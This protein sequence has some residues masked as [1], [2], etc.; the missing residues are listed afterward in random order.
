MR[1]RLTLATL[2]VCASLVSLAACRQQPQGGASTDLAANAQAASAPSQAGVCPQPQKGW[3]AAPEY[4]PAPAPNPDDCF[5]YTAAWQNFLEAT[6][7]D[8]GEAAFLSYPSM[9]AVFGQ[10]AA[11]KVFAN[12]DPRRLSVAARDVQM[13]NDPSVQPTKLVSIA[14][15][16]RQAGGLFG[17]VMDASGRPVYYSIHVNDAF[18]DFV[19]QNGLTTK[20]SV[21]DPKNAGLLFTKGIVELKAA[22]VVTADDDPSNA[23]FLLAHTQLPILQQDNDGVIRLTGQVSAKMVTL[24][25]VALHVAFVIQGHPE[26]IWATFEHSDGDDTSDLAPSALANAASSTLQVRKGIHYLLFAP[27]AARGTSNSPC[28]GLS[29]DECD[30]QPSRPKFDAATQSFTANGKPLQTSIFREFPA[31]KSDRDTPDDSVHSV[32]QIYHGLLKADL[33]GHYRLVG[34]TW[35]ENPLD[36]ADRKGTFVLGRSLTNPPGQDTEDQATRVVSGEDALSS[37]AME[38]FTQRERPSCFSCHNAG[39]VHSDE[40]DAHLILKA[41]RLNVSHVISRYLSNPQ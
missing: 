25:L 32:N 19:Q 38:S 1:T 29:A 40:K 6:K 18:K 16:V 14:D 23:N 7:A 10:A 15:G 4:G 34:A 8:G 11:A 24:K 33:R 27:A 5:F 13:P 20:A 9:A 21:E 35:L 12:L 37:L 28:P 41:T 31:A 2:G 17:L 36:T 26:F 30:K 3:M 22:W 39:P